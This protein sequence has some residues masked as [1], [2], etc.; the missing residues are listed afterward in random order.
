MSSTLKKITQQAPND[1]MRAIRLKCAAE[2]LKQEEY[3]V[4][5]VSYRVGFKNPNYFGTCFRQ[6]YGV[7]PSLYASQFKN[8]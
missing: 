2:L 5:E 4:S 6:I 8:N 7:P 1:F 3:T